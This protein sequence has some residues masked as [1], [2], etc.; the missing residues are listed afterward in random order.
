MI[1]QT[2]FD[3]LRTPI[4]T[5][6]STAL[7]ELNKFVF[8]VSTFADKASVKKAVENIFKVTVTA[9]NILNRVGKSKRFKGTK[10]KRS[11]VKRAIVTIAKGQT[12][13]YT[14]EVK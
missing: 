11:D 3:I 9:V 6:K 12:L 7:S 14:T 4:I 13:D 1:S 8:E 2:S 10:G 5:E